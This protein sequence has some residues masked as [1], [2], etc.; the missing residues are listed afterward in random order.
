VRCQGGSLVQYK[1]T[2]CLLMY[3]VLNIRLSLSCRIHFESALITNHDWDYWKY[4]LCFDPY[5]SRFLEPRDK[6]GSGRLGALRLHAIFISGVEYDI[7]CEMSLIIL[8]SGIYLVTDKR[9][10]KILLRRTHITIHREIII[11]SLLMSPLLHRP[12]LWITHKKN[13]P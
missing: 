5:I 10:W 7:D 3:S 4:K 2:P 13:G 8:R 6:V 9:N 1:N 12:S 11:I